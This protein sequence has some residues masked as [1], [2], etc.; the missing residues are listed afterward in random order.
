MKFRIFLE[1]KKGERK[2]FFMTFFIKKPFETTYIK[3]ENKNYKID[4]QNKNSE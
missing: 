1:N 2:L 3:Y 4:F